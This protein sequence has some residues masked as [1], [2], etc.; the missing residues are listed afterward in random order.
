[1]KLT[2]QVAHDLQQAMKERSE[3]KLSTLRMLKSEL[4]KLQA[5]KGKS[6]EITDEDVFGVIKRLIK[7]RKEAAEQYAAGGA[8]DRAKSELSEI[9]ILEPYLPKQLDDSEIE[10]LIS[11]A[12]TEINAS[13][14]KDMGKLMK[15]VIQK[16]AGR[17]DGS[18]VKNKVMEFLNKK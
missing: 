16:V 2:E 8:S 13:S 18:R 6:F 9:E 1:M 7:Q 4:Q 5:D 10:K 17:A 14:P 15:A 11:E 3:P 12:A